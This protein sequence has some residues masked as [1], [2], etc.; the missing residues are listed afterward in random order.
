[1]SFSLPKRLFPI[2]VRFSY[3][4]ISQGSVATQLRCGWIFNNH[5]ISNFLQ[6]M[7][8]KNSQIGQNLAK[9]WTKVFVACFLRLTVYNIVKVLSS[10]LWLFRYVRRCGREVERQSLRRMPR[11]RH[12]F[13]Y[14]RPSDVTGANSQ[15]VGH[16]RWLSGSLSRDRKV[17][18]RHRAA[19]MRQ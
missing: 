16:S 9:I 3:I 4:H 2:I 18:W 17:R 12:A 11:W 19:A 7:S 6:S 5:V 1:M 13:R 8:V 14:F 10:C 15:Q